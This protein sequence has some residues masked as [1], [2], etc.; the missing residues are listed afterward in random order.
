[1]IKEIITDIIKSCD[2]FELNICDECP[3]KVEC[4]KI[5]MSKYYEVS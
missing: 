1:M 2:A 3:S 5:A 4:C